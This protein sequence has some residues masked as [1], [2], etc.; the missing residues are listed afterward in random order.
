MLYIQRHVEKPIQKP[1]PPDG[2]GSGRSIQEQTIHTTRQIDQYT[3]P[4]KQNEG[5]EMKA[6]AS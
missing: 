6:G 5:L 1:V 3:R 4:G 2:G